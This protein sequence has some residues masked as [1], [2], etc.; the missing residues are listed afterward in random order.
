MGDDETPELIVIPVH[1]LI[2]FDPDPRRRQHRGAR[3]AS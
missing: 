2:P 1:I 3:T